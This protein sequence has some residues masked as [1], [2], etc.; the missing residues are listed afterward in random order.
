MRNLGNLDQVL[1][2]SFHALL[3][4]GKEFVSAKL[5]TEVIH[6]GKVA[7]PHLSTAPPLHLNE[8][9]GQGNLVDFYLRIVAHALET[10]DSWK[11][12]ERTKIWRNSQEFFEHDKYSTIDS[13]L[14]LAS[15][16]GYNNQSATHSTSFGV[17][18]KQITTRLPLTKRK[19]R[20]RTVDIEAGTPPVK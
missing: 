12:A 9:S 1:E 20:S 7:T 17:I 16:Q 18:I 3:T 15:P 10:N 19:F 13:M 14:T 2:E 5:I 6:R 4:C 11:A 8:N